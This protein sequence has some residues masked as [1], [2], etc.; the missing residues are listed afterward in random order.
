MLSSLERRKTDGTVRDEATGGTVLQV[1]DLRVGGVVSSAQPQV[2]GKT[3]WRR[4]L[5]KGYEVRGGN[6]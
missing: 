1:D 3:R 2:V 4:R 5:R 6:K